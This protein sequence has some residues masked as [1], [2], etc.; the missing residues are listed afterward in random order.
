MQPLL[1]TFLELLLCNGV[2]CCRY[3]IWMSL[4]WNLC[5]F[6]EDFIFRNNH[7]SFGVKSVEKGGCSISVI[8]FWARNCLTESALWAGAL[9]WWRIKSLGQ[10]SVLSLLTV[11]YSASIFPHNKLGWLSGLV[12]WI[13]SKQYPWY[14]IKSWALVFICDFDMRASWIVRISAVSVA[15]F[16][17]CFQ[18][19]IESITQV[20]LAFFPNVTQN[21]TLFRW[22]K[23]RSLIL[24][25]NVATHVLSAPQLPYN[26]R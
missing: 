11:S 24:R 1:E 23:N 10:S 13:Q 5:P 3:I 18:D 9:P 6:K 19:H 25:R 8:D 2:Q 4:S 21:W 17:A 7:K 16:L 22:S 20:S 14:R 15:N 26:L 12:E